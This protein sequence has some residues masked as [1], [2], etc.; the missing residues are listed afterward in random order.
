M[1]KIIF[2]LIVLSIIGCNNNE[3]SLNL[4]PFKQKDNYGYFDLEGKI[5]INPQFGYATPFAENLALIKTSG[6][7][8][9]WGYIDE[10][11]NYSINAIYKDATIFNEGIAFVVKENDAPT[12]IDNEGKTL[13]VLKDVDKVEIFH[14][15]L[16]AFAISDSTNYKWGFINKDGEK[17]INSQFYDVGVFS[18]GRCA[19]KNK[20]GKWGFIDKN[21]KL[22]INYQFEGASKFIEGKAVVY[23]EKKAGVIDSEGKYIINP[24]FDDAEIDNNSFLIKQNDK[25]GWCNNEGKIVINP[26]FEEAIIFGENKITPVKSGESYGY[27]NNEGKFVINP[28]FDEAYPFYNDLAIVKT[29]DK[30]GLIDKEGKYKVNPQFENLSFDLFIYLNTNGRIKSFHTNIDSDYIDASSITNVINFDKPEGVTFTNTF[31]EIALKFNKKAEDFNAYNEI[32]SL[33]D[34]KK[35]NNYAKYSFAAMGKAKDL[36][37]NYQYYITSNTPNIFVY[38]FDLENRALGKAESISKAFEASFKSL[39]KIKEGYIEDSHNIVYSKSNYKIVLSVENE[40]TIMVYI[41]S[42]KFDLTNYLSKI[43]P[44]KAI[45]SKNISDYDKT[46]VDTTAVEVDSA[47]AAYT[48]DY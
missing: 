22:I 1:R 10:K 47:A 24:Q 13:F 11:G 5:V 41:V 29:G 43:K 20:E 23:L 15:S 35:I 27:I 17:T 45:D 48:E 36:N 40:N 3:N 4:I 18:D 42:D 9:K 37:N 8:G 34:Y 32:N 7:K 21:G 2:G 38:K 19:V 30:Y 31:K 33:I 12:A 16:A 28:Q 39:K 25:Y 14:E 44:E 6:D 46:D 26:Q